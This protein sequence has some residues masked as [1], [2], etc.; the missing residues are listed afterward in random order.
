MAYS[1][2]S[3]IGMIMF[4]VAAFAVPG[5]EAGASD[6][7]GLSQ[8]ISIVIGRTWVTVVA[9]MLLRSPQPVGATRAAPAVS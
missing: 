4:F 8:R 1:L 2:A 5:R 7:A 9:L 3:G 6:F